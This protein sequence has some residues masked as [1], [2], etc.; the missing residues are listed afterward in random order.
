MKNLFCEKEL[1]MNESDVENLFVRRL[2]ELLEYEDRLIKT[3]K[4]LRDSV[5]GEG[6]KK[7]NYRP[8]YVCNFENKPKIVIEAKSPKENID[9]YTY[10]VSGYAL[11]L[12]KEFKGENPVRFTILTNGLHFKLYNWDEEEPILI[13]TF[14]DFVKGNKKFKQLKELIGLQSIKD[15]TGKDEM[16]ITDFLSK[17]SVEKIKSAFNK[18]HNI[19]WKK[20]KISPTDAFYEFSKIIFV[21]LNEDKRIRRT[22]ESGTQLKR[23]DFKFSVEWLDER[24]SEAENPLSSILFA[25]LQKK[26]QE[27]VE[28][29]KKKPIFNK[30]EGIELKAPTIKE[31]V[32][33]LQDYDL[34][35][36]D[37]DLNGRMFETF[38]NATIRGKELGQYFTPRK[39]VKF[40]TKLADLQIKRK[41]GEMIVDHVLDACC[42]SGGFLIDTMA[43]LT[44][45]VKSNTSLKPY[46]KEAVETI[47]KE[48]I[49]GIEANPKIS[50]I[51]RMN[52]YVHGDGG[53]KIYCADS[54]DKKISIWK[55]TDK[56][57][58]KE[59][60]E[61]REI[62]IKKRRKFDVVL[63][64]PPFS[65]VYKSK[66]KD[67]KSILKQYGD[68]KEDK[69]ISYIKGK[70]EIKSSVKSNILFIARYCDLLKEGG[71]M[72]I[73][74]DNSVLNSYSHTDYRNFIRKNFIIKAIFQLPTHT[75]VNQEA[76]GI[77]SILYLEKRFSKEQEQSH[78]FARMINKVGHGT[79]G[80]EEKEDDFD[81]ALR[82]YK[83]F[84]ETGRLYL[85]G[86]EEIG[87]F[88]NDDLFLIDPK[89]ILDRIDVFFH[90]P[91]Y[92]KLLQFL[93]K[94]EKN[95]KC[96][97]KK[98]ED[99][100]IVKFM[101]KEK[102][103]ELETSG[104]DLIYQYIDI[105]SID[106]ER[107][108]IMQDKLQVGTKEELPERAKLVLKT[109]DVL[110]SKPFRSLKKVA[111]VPKELNKQFGSS[112]FWGIRP[113][114]YNEACLLWGIFRSK[115]IQK[116]F[117]HL[118]SGYTQR[119]LNDEYLK[120]YL[121]IPI[122]KNSAKSAKIISDNIKKAKE[123]RK[124]ELEAIDKIL[125]EPI[126]AIG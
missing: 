9:N 115:L 4:S 43:D 66:D 94:K 23:T 53:S 96:K 118:A 10:Q 12:N 21:K 7:R 100:N 55:G 84:E 114:D 71:R 63:T 98:L 93:H 111:I 48:A 99:Y 37:E 68:T 126:K 24:E 108:F 29:K 90:Q 83:K 42:G 41:N 32:R 107:G 75:F 110:F 8:D 15:Q 49:F 109:N 38:L 95:K 44:E 89:M 28:Q 80:K 33:I 92:N 74:L 3:K 22:I 120:K 6:S 61:L 76:G 105:T 65:M 77:T 103:I 70:S 69:N 123:S 26:L 97:L 2:L 27:D 64:N 51:A 73:I 58:K 113:N 14:E 13:L 121:I 67:E 85:K 45:K 60:K 81:D 39:V 35:T 122:P 57:I 116:Q 62:L 11:N 18:C 87:G 47:K 30:D 52:M 1:L 82:E 104:D 106:K 91:S 25:E 102:Q 40:M 117:I 20:E 31:V 72:F 16:L 79:S 125:T 46:L 119:E 36:I 5:I 101:S 56:G 88:E 19:I 17:P 34:Y 124:K 59:L 86:E 112:G 50:R 54:L 78:I